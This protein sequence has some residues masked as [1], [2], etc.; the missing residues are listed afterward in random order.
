MRRSKLLE[1]SI[2]SVWSVIY[3]CNLCLI[4]PFSLSIYP[5]R[6][7]KWLYMWRKKYVFIILWLK[8]FVTL[9]TNETVTGEMVIQG[10]RLWPFSWILRPFLETVRLNFVTNCTSFIYCTNSVF[11][12][13]HHCDTQNTRRQR[14]LVCLRVQAWYRIEI[15]ELTNARLSVS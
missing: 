14:E 3:N 5:W 7:Q 2:L 13:T 10:S 9:W 12:F 1:K 8:H 6:K 4:Y 11:F 15:G